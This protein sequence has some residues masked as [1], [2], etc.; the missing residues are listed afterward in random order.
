[1]RAKEPTGGLCSPALEATG[2]YQV[3]KLAGELVGCAE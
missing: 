2:L 1:M 3:S